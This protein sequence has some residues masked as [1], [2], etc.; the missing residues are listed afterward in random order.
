MSKETYGVLQQHVQLVLGH[1]H[2]QLVAGVDDEDDSLALLVVVLPQ[3]AI[4]PLPGHV[5]RREADISVWNEEEGETKGKR[6]P[7]N[8]ESRSTSLIV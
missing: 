3:V 5:E 4:P 2:A 8:L 1:H 7:F 6:R